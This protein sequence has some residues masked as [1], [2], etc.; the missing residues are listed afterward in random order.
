[1]QDE[2]MQYSWR[3]TCVFFRV[4]FELSY[5]IENVLR[6][7]GVGSWW[8]WHHITWHCVSKW[9]L[10]LGWPSERIKQFYVWFDEIKCHG[11]PTQNSPCNKSV[12]LRSTM[13]I[14]ANQPLAS[15]GSSVVVPPVLLPPYEPA[16]WWA[17]TILGVN[18]ARM[19]NGLRVT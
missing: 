1:M 18:S 8:N 4:F 14:W 7:W 9:T 16:T 6:F 12:S 3:R 13:Y 19:S 11:W 17:R 15:T 2:L 5:W 10:T